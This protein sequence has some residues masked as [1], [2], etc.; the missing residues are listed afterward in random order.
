MKD[1]IS[2][3][4]CVYNRDD[5]VS[6][7][8]LSVLKQTYQNFEFIIVDD[9]SI[10]KTVD[11]IKSFNDSRIHLIENSHNGIA[12]SREICLKNCN[13]KYAAIIDSDDIMYPD[14]LEKQYQYMEDN[15]YIDILSCSMDYINDGGNVF[16]GFNANDEDVD[17][18]KLSKGNCLSNSASFMRLSSI[19]N[20]KLH[21]KKSFDF[22]EDY[23]F[24]ADAAIANLKIKTIPLKTTKYRKHA[25]NITNA[26]AMTQ[27]KLAERI[28]KELCDFANGNKFFITFSNS[29]SNFSFDRIKYEANSM[30]CFNGINCYTE[31][32]F[33]SEYWN[34]H[35]DN[36]KG[37][38]GFGYW[39]WKP[40]FLKKKLSEMNDG[41]IVV[42]ADTGCMLLKD[43]VEELKRWFGIA[44]ASESGILSPCFGPYLEHEWSRYDL[45]DYINKTYNK[46]NIDIF[47]KAIQCGA[48]VLIICKNDNSVDFV[49]QWNDIMSNHF[50]LCTDEPSS[51][52]NH[53]NFHENRHDQSAFSMLSKIYGIETINTKDGIINKDKSPIICTR[54]KND[55]Y[56]WQK[57]VRVLFDNQIYDLQ[58]FGGISRMFVD[59]H[60]ELDKNEIVENFTGSSI[61]RGRYNSIETSFS[62]LNTNNSYLSKTKPYNINK[63]GNNREYT[64]ELLKK[65][66][67][68]IFY[69]TFFDTYFIPYLNGKPFVISIHDMIPELYP[70]FFSKN[71]MQIVGKRIMAQYAAAIEV[72]TETTKKD[73]IRLLGVDENKVH[74][75]GRGYDEKLGNNISLEKI[76]DFKY[77]LYVGQRNAYKRF[78]WFIKHISSFLNEHKDVKLVCTGRDFSNQELQLFNEY[79][80]ADSIVHIFANDDELARLYRDAICFIYSSE[81]EGFGIPILEAYKMN[82]IAVLNGNDECFKEVTDNKG[83]FF[84]MSENQSNLTEVL[85]NILNLNK[86]EKDSIIKIQKEILAKYSWKKSA[87][88]L[89]DIFKKVNKEY[90]VSDNNVTNDDVDIFICAHKDFKVY[91]D[92]DVYTIVHGNEKISVPLKQISES[93]DDISPM[94]FSFAEGSRMYYLWKNYGFKKYVGFC[95]Y[96]KYFSFFDKVPDI[97]KIFKNYDVILANPIKCGNIPMEYGGYH[98]INDLMLVKDIIRNKFKE[99][100]SA[101][102]RACM[103]GIMFPCNMF[104]M[105]SDDYK[106][107]CSFVF[108]VLKEFTKERGFKSDNDIK[109]YVKK[110]SNEYLK[111]YYPN[112]TIE[113]QSRMCGFL[114]ERLTNAYIFYKFK[115]PL[116]FS[117][118][119]TETKYMK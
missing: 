61:A 116:C 106:E 44:Y 4:M 73:V 81:Y 49:N 104:I 93:E 60:N 59:L 36:F 32:D 110:H 79:G 7:T 99:Y 30:K 105:K 41:D 45:Y 9:G 55:R 15:P 78:D 69:P 88:K 80:I 52:P 17:A 65:G 3:L 109:I 98:N 42:Y 115:N 33:D 47:D 37:T 83:T 111:N 97:D 75:I 85:N 112:N 6:E 101:F 24:W 89:S 31:K 103:S 91:P 40:Y 34:K 2:V 96:R 35:K 113:Y 72:P 46:D 18:E 1:L 118:M 63:N 62:V 8:I 67:F 94:Q 107:Y 38:R 13:G 25:G 84:E 57:P 12:V 43:N 28:R 21:Y 50:H 58:T 56:T 14:R 100:Y 68:D 74:V 5:Y 39:A 26:H 119:E 51:L 92:N 71:D 27:I 66:D 20:A 77:I 117:I 64:I 87:D 48:G 108:G 10:D 22:C 11:I 86:E 19:K 95:H 70:Q 23:R 16:G 29:D 54:C 114:L 53:P 82:C 90:N 102:I 76:F